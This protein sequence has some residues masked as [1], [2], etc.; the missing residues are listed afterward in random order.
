MVK[1]SELFICFKK[2]NLGYIK[3][4]SVIFTIEKVNLGKVL[5]TDFKYSLQLEITMS[6]KGI[7][8]KC[9]SNFL[10]NQCC[11]AK[12]ACLGN[13]R[14][15]LFTHNVSFLSSTFFYYTF[16]FHLFLEN[17]SLRMLVFFS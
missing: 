1:I 5:N 7:S 10:V 13:S 8:R 4:S 12:A 15:P 9:V 16:S 11:G 2:A 6:Y 17:L 14:S 3:S